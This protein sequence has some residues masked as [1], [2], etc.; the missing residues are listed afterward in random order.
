MKTET[1][2]ITTAGAYTAEI[3]RQRHAARGDVWSTR[4]SFAIREN[5]RHVFG[6]H[7]FAT[8]IACHAAL[9]SCLTSLTTER[10]A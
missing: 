10:A 8:M 9:R 4:Y 7:G 3:T 6:G 2:S 1:M 5:G